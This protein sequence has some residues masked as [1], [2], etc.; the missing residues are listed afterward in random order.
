MAISSK[1]SVQRIEVYPLADS[2]AAD[3]ANAKHPT[4]M[5][6]Y[7]NTLT[8][9]GAD[10]HLDGTVATEVKHLSKFVEDGGAATD[11]SGEEALVKTVCAAI[12]A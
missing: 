12:W 8:G 3:T 5:V 9:T 2:T 10:A 6:V 11:Y 4:V 1:Q 7:E